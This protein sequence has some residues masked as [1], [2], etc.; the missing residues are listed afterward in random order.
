[1]ENTGRFHWMVATIR[2]I[3]VT[4]YC[5][6]VGKMHVMQCNWPV[7]RHLMENH[8]AHLLRLTLTEHLLTR[9]VDRL[10]NKQIDRKRRQRLAINRC[11]LQMPSQIH[12]HSLSAVY[13]HSHLA[14][15]VFRAMKCISVKPK[16]TEAARF[17][18]I[19]A[20]NGGQHRGVPTRKSKR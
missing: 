17:R 9:P 4:D 1:M 8:G 10:E 19:G 2:G 14:N 16:R 7:S 11:K 20:I 13:L 15:C 18:K 6:S 5:L 3:I 12:T